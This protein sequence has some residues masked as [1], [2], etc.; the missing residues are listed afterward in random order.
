MNPSRRPLIA[1]NWKMFNG[2][3][4]GVELAEG[5]V[6]FARDLPGVDVVIAPPFT[7]L[8]A[9]A[10][11]I[12]G[13]PVQ[14]AAQN[15]Y[16]KDQGAFTG[17]ISGPMLE[18][19]GCTWVIVGHSERR[20]YFAE[21][22]SFVA[23][24]TSAALRHDLLPIVCVGETLQQREAGETLRV[25]KQQVDAFLDVI[26]QTPKAVAI[27]YEPIWAIGTGKTAGPTEAEEVHAA[28]RSWLEK[29]NAD[30]A[31]RTRILYG[32]SVKP[33]NATALLACPNVDGF[34]VGGASLDAGSFGAIAKAARAK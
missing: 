12:D 16:P 31:K 15:V 2:G 29:K 3:R 8:A 6:A 19:C 13:S 30:L 10:D 5:C 23:D 26:A 11:T 24:K 4:S 14:L 7:A 27:A 20:Q 17:E 32:G 28:I 34:L 9:V 33:D 1:G 25:V 22:D 21:T 18:E